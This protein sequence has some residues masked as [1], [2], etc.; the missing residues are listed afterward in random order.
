MRM[1]GGERQD[2]GLRVKRGCVRISAALETPLCVCLC[3][4]ASERLYCIYKHMSNSHKPRFPL[5]LWRKKDEEK[6][7][8]SAPKQKKYEDPR[9]VV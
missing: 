8:V 1:E 4:H 5:R 9:V 2:G 6:A 7:E 3:L